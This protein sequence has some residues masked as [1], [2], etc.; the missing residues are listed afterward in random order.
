MNPRA[1]H[2]TSLLQMLASFWRNRRIIWRQKSVIDANCQKVGM[3]ARHKRVQLPVNWRRLESSPEAIERDV[4]YAI[5]IGE[6]Y[7]KLLEEKGLSLKGLS[8]LEL[9]P[10]HNHGTA[11]VLACHGADVSVADRFPV[12]W[13][14]GYHDKFHRALFERI[15]SLWPM[16]NT[17]PLV[18]CIEKSTT[19]EV[20]KVFHS[21]AEDLLGVGNETMDV[22]LSN[23]V[24]EHVEEPQRAAQELFRVTKKDGIGL[25]QIDFRDHRDF[26]RPLEYLLLNDSDFIK[27]FAERNGECGRQ[28]RHFEMKKLF[29]KAGFEVTG[30]DVNWFASDEYLDDFIPRLRGSSSAYRTIPRNELR[31]TSGRFSLHKPIDN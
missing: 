3:D 15:K 8:T 28:T 19:E 20:V 6:E 24:L 18:Y 30:F 16:L 12:Q 21:T 31:V 1:Q 5:K 22:V 10:G 14:P 11:L 29:Q 4:L 17:T 13:Q 26:T 23:A 27:L 2:S 25:H 7:K 9:G